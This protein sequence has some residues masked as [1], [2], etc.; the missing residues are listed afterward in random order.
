MRFAT[1]LP[2]LDEALLLQS[3][4][5]KLSSPSTRALKAFRQ[6]FTF[7]ELPVLWG[8]D[9]SLL[10][11]D[12][13]LVALAPTETDRLDAFLQDYLGWFFK[14]SSKVKVEP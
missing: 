1:G 2:G 7:G 13:D 9:R 6:W 3:Q 10:T 12:R 11:D 5:L 8:H 14:V 4:I